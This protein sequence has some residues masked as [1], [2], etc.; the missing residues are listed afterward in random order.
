MKFF[1]SSHLHKSFWRDELESESD[2]AFMDAYLLVEL[3]SS[4]CRRLVNDSEEEENDEEFTTDAH[5]STTLFTTFPPT[6]N[7]FRA[8]IASID[9]LR[10]CPSNKV[11]AER[12]AARHL[13][14]RRSNTRAT[15]KRNII[16]SIAFRLAPGDGFGVSSSVT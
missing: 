4:V 15:S 2:V 14:H 7:K 3:E 1:T 11:F 5:A 12:S 13:P 9:Y 8:S 6:D 16:A 10:V